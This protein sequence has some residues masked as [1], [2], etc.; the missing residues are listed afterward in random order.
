[1]LKGLFNSKIFNLF[2]FHVPNKGAVDEG[3]YDHQN[4]GTE[5]HTETQGHTESQ[6]HT[7]SQY[8][9]QEHGMTHAQGATGESGGS[10][11]GSADSGSLSISGSHNEPAVGTSQ[12]ETE[13]YPEVD[14]RRPDPNDKYLP[15]V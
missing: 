10:T 12:G 9:G 7:D 4:H 14:I 13:Q 1:M 8:L 11:I 5:G 2:L 6:G 3:N 15:A